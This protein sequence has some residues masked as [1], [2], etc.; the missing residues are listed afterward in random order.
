MLYPHEVLRL[1]PKDHQGPFLA[2]KNFL[3]KLGKS[4]T[5]RVINM[6]SDFASFS[7]MS[8]QGIVLGLFKEVNI[9]F[10]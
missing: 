6:S 9:A 7:G 10:G 4:Q 8:N 2:T 1:S 5:P 3:P